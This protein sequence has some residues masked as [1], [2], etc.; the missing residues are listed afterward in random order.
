MSNSDKSNKAAAGCMSI[1]FKIGLA[2][3]CFGF[4][5]WE[6]H[7]LVGIACIIGIIITLFVIN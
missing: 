5:T 7:N 2:I 4:A 3:Y 1:A 6:Y